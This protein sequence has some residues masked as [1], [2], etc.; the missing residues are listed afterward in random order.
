MPCK[1]EGCSRTVHARGLCNSHYNVWRKQMRRRGLVAVQVP[2]AERIS[3]YLPGTVEEIAAS[4]EHRYE[5]AHRT[6]MDMHAA[7]KL[8]ISAYKPPRHSGDKWR[9]VFSMGPGEDVDLTADT[10]R[11]FANSRRNQLQRARTGHRAAFASVLA[12]LLN[13]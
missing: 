8:F 1:R 12:P 5:W 13:H 11:L 2:L 4:S 7:K 6:V 10:K 9:P 3:F